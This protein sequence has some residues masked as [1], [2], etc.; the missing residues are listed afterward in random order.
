MRHAG[1]RP[2]KYDY[3]IVGAGSAGCVLANRLS[4]DPSKR[5]LLIEAGASDRHLL[6]RIPAATWRHLGNEKRDWRY[7]T[8]PDASRHN[9]VE[10]WSRGKLLGGSSSINGMIYVRGAKEDFDHWADLGNEGWSYQDVLPLFKRLES[11]EFSRAANSHSEHYGGQ[12]LLKIRQMRGAH[13]LS[14][15][16][17]SACAD[18][19]I[20]PNPHY[21]AAEQD[22]ACILSMTQSTRLRYSSSRAFLEPVQSRRNLSVLTNTLVTKVLVEEKRAI[23]VCVTGKGSDRS[24]EIYAEQVILSAGAINSPQLLMLSG[25]GPAR[26]LL[27]VGVPVHHD[28]PGVGQN[29][30]DHPACAIRARVNVPTLSTRPAAAVRAG[31]DWLLF[32][33]GPLMSAACQALAFVKT[34]TDLENPDVQIH[35]MPLGLF[36]D[37]RNR[38]QIVDS[39]ITLLANVSRTRSRGE[40][41]LISSSPYDAPAIYPNMLG[42]EADVKVLMAAGRLC[43]QLLKTKSLTPYVEQETSPGISVQTDQQWEEF[44]RQNASTAYH[45]CGTCKMG[46]DRMAVVDRRLK[47]H[48]LEGLR[49]IDG[50]IMPTILSGNTNAACMMIGE[51]GADLI[52]REGNPSL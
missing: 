52:L 49:V 9:R 32:G 43:R 11:H 27:E 30:Q 12:G 17:V 38:I 31:M 2:V 21:N 18:L 3:V 22:G 23:G 44:V 48:G 25:I 26:H 36:K 34:H 42:D 35:M 24:S 13:A 50:S 4:A 40:L 28:L 10:I 7:E 14:H 29:L 15:V 47:V 1:K 46:T 16:F 45:H 41:K 6:H 19:G 51:K 33:R 37:E 20:H 5:V 8:Q 39:C